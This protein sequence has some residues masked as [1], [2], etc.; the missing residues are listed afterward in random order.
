M[1][2]KGRPKC[3]RIVK[4]KPGIDYFKPRGTPLNKLK[5]VILSIEEI[6]AMRLVDLE[7]L[8]QE[9]AAKEM[10]VSRRTLARDLKRGR[11]KTVEALVEGKAIEIRGG[12]FATEDGVF[13]CRE[14]SHEWVAP[15]GEGKPTRCP[16]C[17]VKDIRRMIQNG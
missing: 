8:E 12:F 14:C 17:D 4:D 7:G 15:S 6:E 1:H 9:K 11:K 10:K 5:S 2:R 3:I 16:E 13:I